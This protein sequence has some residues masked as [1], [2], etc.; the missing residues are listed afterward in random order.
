M[1]T[2]FYQKKK[3]QPTKNKQG[4]KQTN[5]QNKNKQTKQNKIKQNK[6]PLK[7]CV[8]FP[9]FGH[10]EQ[11]WKA[12]RMRIGTKRILCLLYLYN[13]GKLQS[14]FGHFQKFKTACIINNAPIRIN[15][16]EREI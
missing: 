10:V 9:G 12:T 5:K 11:S 3:N 6:K 8:I 4:N 14:P 15:R 2:Q 13:I 7:V 1:P 16:R